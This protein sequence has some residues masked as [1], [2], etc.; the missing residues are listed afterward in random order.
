M[1]IGSCSCGGGGKAYYSKGYIV[2]LNEKNM[3][4]RKRGTE[5]R[6]THKLRDKEAY[7]E[8]LRERVEGKG[9]GEAKGEGT[10]VGEL[11]I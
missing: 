5:R 10:G 6:H 2:K 4:M 3:N 9:E 7:R 8:T 11:M 1:D